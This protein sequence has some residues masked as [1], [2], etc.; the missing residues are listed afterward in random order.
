MTIFAD[1]AVHFPKLGFGSIVSAEANLRDFTCECFF[2]FTVRKILRASKGSL[3]DLLRAYLDC[4]CPRTVRAS[5]CELFLLC[6]RAHLPGKLLKGEILMG[7]TLTV[8][9]LPKRRN[10]FL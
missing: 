7:N 3:A 9:Y 5:F 2:I 4:V 10:C 6:T 8:K 1:A